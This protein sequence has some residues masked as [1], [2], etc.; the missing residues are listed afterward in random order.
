METFFVDLLRH[1]DDLAR[2]NGGAKFA[3][4]AA[5]LL[6]SDFGHADSTTSF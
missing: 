5:I 2:A 1:D 4:L 3:T 6:E